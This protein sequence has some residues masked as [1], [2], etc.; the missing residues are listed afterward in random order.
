MIFYIHPPLLDVP[1]DLLRDICCK[2]MALLIK[3]DASEGDVEAIRRVLEQ[4]DT[5]HECLHEGTTE[6][7]V[8]HFVVRSVLVTQRSALE[9][10]VRAEAMLFRYRFERL[11]WDEKWG[12]LGHIR[13]EVQSTLGC[14]LAQDYRNVLETLTKV[15]DAMFGKWDDISHDREFEVQVPFEHALSLVSTR[16]VTLNRGI[17]TV[18]TPFLGQL[19]T[20]LFEETLRRGIEH[21]G[22]SANFRQLFQDK[23]MV[24][25]A[26]V[27][28]DLV[29]KKH[30]HQVGRGLLLWSQ[31]AAES[32]WFP[33]CMAKMYSML[34]RE[35]RLPH[36]DRFRL[37]LFLKELGLPV[38][39]SL[40]LWGHFYSRR[41]GRGATCG[42][43]WQTHN[44]Q[45]RYSVCHMYGLEGARKDYT[46]HGCR[47]LQ[48]TDHCPF[49]ARAGPGD[50]G[51]DGSLSAADMEDLGR[52]CRDGRA[53]AA[54]RLHL[55]RSARP[56]C[57][58]GI[59][60]M[61][62]DDAQGPSVHFQKPSQYYHA[63]KSLVDQL[64]GQSDADVD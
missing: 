19:L 38:S 8:S 54:C 39:E 48:D 15:L 29:S 4:D 26:N 18:M 62:L 10:V 45:L 30:S 41:P 47:Q 34:L 64:G 46:A 5:C 20:C 40:L 63:F 44:R 50:F 36:E 61:D 31:V 1:L 59:D 52:L 25:L 11:S 60:L 35:N 56:L 27:L 12:I 23:R 22:R 17:A 13:E 53:S 55:V 28:Q 58:E 24:E 2:R 3:I 14:K 42:H 43:G 32:F 51:T 37:T 21:F 6:D 9:H 57:P 33:P 7:L 16:S 49:V